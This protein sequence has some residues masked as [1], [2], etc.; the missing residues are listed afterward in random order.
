M[1]MWVWVC[2]YKVI[3]RRRS[4][5]NIWRGRRKEEEKYRCGINPAI[6]ST[7]PRYAPAT[8]DSNRSVLSERME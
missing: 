5:A 7:G 8:A 1:P 6:Q 3:L 2:H 4:M